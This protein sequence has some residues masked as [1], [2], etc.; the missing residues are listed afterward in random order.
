MSKILKNIYLGGKAEAKNS[1]LLK[2]LNIK[3]ILN[4]TPTRNLDPENGC[5]NFFEKERLFKYQRIPIF[6]NRG[7][8]L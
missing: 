7:T 3:Y 8:F 2:S 1:N 4:C 5:P 6:D